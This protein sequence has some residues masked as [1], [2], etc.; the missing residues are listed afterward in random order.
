MWSDY[1]YEVRG[2]ETLETEY[3][4][5]IYEVQKDCVY[6]HHAYTRPDIRDKGIGKKLMFEVSKIAKKHDKNMLMCGVDLDTFTAN[7]NLLRYLH[8]GAKVWSVE[9]PFIYLYLLL[10]DIEKNSKYEEL[11]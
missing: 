9:H 3:G 10:E 2:W 7:K 4:F 5:A 1:F 8:N 6:I 11:K